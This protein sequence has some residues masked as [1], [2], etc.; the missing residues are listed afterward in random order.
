[1]SH[2]NVLIKKA[3]TRWGIVHLKLTAHGPRSGWATRKRLEGKPFE[4][5]REDGRWES[6]KSLRIYLDVVTATNFEPLVSHMRPMAQW[7]EDD[8]YD[9]FTLWRGAPPE[10]LLVRMLR[11]VGG[12]PGGS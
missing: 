6:D 9:R 10:S 4:E 12:S 7:L 5:L 2:Y 1:M 3:H 8:F 11:D